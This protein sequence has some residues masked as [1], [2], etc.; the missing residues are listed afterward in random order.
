M[1]AMQGV[2][3]TQD[4]AALSFVRGLVAKPFETEP[5][6]S[7]FWFLV[8]NLAGPPPLEGNQ[9]TITP[10][11]Q[12][13]DRLKRYVTVT[14]AAGTGGT[15]NVSAADAKYIQSGQ[16]LYFGREVIN[17]YSI[18]GGSITAQRGFGNSQV[19]TLAVGDKLSIGPRVLSEGSSKGESITTGPEWTSNTAQTFDE[20]AAF[21][22][23]ELIQ[24]YYH[25]RDGLAAKI[26]YQKRLKLLALR[27]KEETHILTAGNAPTKLAA[28]ATGNTSSLQPRR[29]SAGLPYYIRALWDM[30]HRMTWD[31]LNARM[32]QKI[33]YSRTKQFVALG[34]TSAI[35]AIQSW[36]AHRV[37]TTQDETS[38]GAV[39]HTVFGGGWEVKLMTSN[40][41]TGPFWGSALWIFDTNSIF[42]HPYR[43]L[44]LMDNVQTPGDDA[45][46]M[47]WIKGGCVCPVAPKSGALVVNVI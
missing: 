42:Y 30:N 8:E 36:G 24:M 35:G 46:A 6:K 15:I 41:M 13:Q 20:N 44:E 17:A 47:R 45:R 26:E 33:P 14:N 37:R 25:S 4:E 5:E 27:D 29:F 11:W 40:C 34:S 38:V 32:Q 2:R 28:A 43:P 39:V 3:G 21:T 18:S 12:R 31:V 1:N 9:K 7:D 22:K 10:E 16:M 23:D 19:S